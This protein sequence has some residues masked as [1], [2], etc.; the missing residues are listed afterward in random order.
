MKSLIDS[1]YTKHKSE[2]ICQ[3]DIYKDVEISFG[4]ESDGTEK[5]IEF[6]YIVVLTQ[7]CD[8]EQDHDNQKIIETNPTSKTDKILQSI[9]VSPAYLA[10]SLK[11]GTHLNDLGLVMEYQGTDAWKLIKSNQKARY[12]FLNAYPDLQIPELVIDFKHYYT[13]YKKR[14]IGLQNNYI[15]S[16]NELFRENLSQKFSNYLARIGLPN[17]AEL[18][19]Q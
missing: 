11:Q 17:L 6:P 8:L 10:D 5:I 14:L 4:I 7:D 13:I 19:D 2:R 9:L 3:G 16:I 15:G 18:G 12:Y 1:P